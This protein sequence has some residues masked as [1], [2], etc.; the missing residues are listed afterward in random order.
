MTLSRS[1]NDVHP[2]GGDCE[3]AF[4]SDCRRSAAALLAMWRPPAL[5]KPPASFARGPGLYQSTCVLLRCAVT[6]RQYRDL[7]QVCAATT[8]GV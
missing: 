3:M 1:G 4:R 2:S 7:S 6:Q 5:R 8:P